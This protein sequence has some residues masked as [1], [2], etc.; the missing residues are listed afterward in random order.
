MT[1]T[2]A[3]TMTNL[4]NDTITLTTPDADAMYGPTAFVLDTDGQ[5]TI[6]GSDH[7][8]L[9]ISGGN[10]LRPFVVTATASLTLEDL[11]ISGGLARGWR[12][13]RG[14]RRWRWRWRR[15]WRGGGVYVDGGSFTADGVTFVNN[16]AIGGAGG[17]DSLSGY[18]GGNGGKGLGGAGSA[19]GGTSWSHVAGG[20]GGFGGGGGGG[21]ASSGAGGGGGLAAVAVAADPPR[22][23]GGAGGFGGGAGGNLEHTNG[24]GGGG[25]GAGLGGGIFANGGSVTLI[26][27]TLTANSATGGAKG[28][29]VN[30]DGDFG[31]AYG[32]RTLQR[33][34]RRSALSIPRFP[35]TRWRMG[36]AHPAT[37]RTFT[38]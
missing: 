11:T 13:R 31:S 36:I 3:P 21:A 32:G 35:R 26:N 15:C 30:I 16:S 17:S 20:G 19:A 10:T 8:G 24:G 25:G 23:A 38:C 29:G 12:R 9:V 4:V 7:P 27:S 1:I 33:A 22:R 34:T 28:T 2:F 6:D 5:I 18:N 37:A 14:Q